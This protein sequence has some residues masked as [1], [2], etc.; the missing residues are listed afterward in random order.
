VLDALRSIATWLADCSLANCKVVA[1]DA[2]SAISAH[3]KTRAG[4]AGAGLL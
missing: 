1:V 4:L 3:E 2:A